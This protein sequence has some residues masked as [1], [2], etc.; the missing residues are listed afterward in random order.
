MK[1]TVQEQAILNNWPVVTADDIELMNDEF[2]HYIFFRRQKNGSVEYHTSCCGRTERIKPVRRTELP[3]GNAL[4]DASYHNQLHTCP[5]CSRKVT[6]KDLS[7]AGKRK[8]LAASCL[9][10]L[11]HGDK[12][13]LYADALSLRKDY[14]TLT[15]LTARPTYWL[16]SG[17][18]FSAGEVMEIDYQVGGEGCI[19]WERGQLGRKKLVQEPFKKGSLSSYTHDPY[20]V[21]GRDVLENHPLFRYCQYFD[22]WQYRPGGPR[23]HAHKFD[24]LIS[25]LTAYSMYPRQ[26]ELLVKAGLFQPVAELIW[27]RKKFAAAI[28]W[29]EPDIRKAMDLSKGELSQLLA[30][31]PDFGA[32]ECRAYATR[33]LG[34]SWDVEDAATFWQIWGLDLR[35]MVVLRFCRRYQ[36]PL[37]KLLRYLDRV[38]GEDSSGSARA[39]A[40]GVYSDY[41]DAAYHLGRCME[42]SAVLWP[43]LLCTAHDEA[44]DQWAQI[45]LREA[46]ADKKAGRPKEAK[47]RAR[48]YEFELGDLCIKFP[49]SAAAIRLEGQRL[50]HCVGGY[51]KRHLEGVLTILFLRKMDMP[52]TPY[53]TIEMQGN[54]LRQIHGLC[55][56]IGR[57]SPRIKHKGFLDTWM[58]W[59]R[60]GSPRNEDGSPQLPK[61]KCGGV[62]A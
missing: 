40:F 35:P 47:E 21:I 3:W 5:W 6:M 59:L 12:Q 33:H 52:N 4:L 62:V 25:Y 61:K 7:K 48:K 55:N 54:Q 60:E 29:E 53:V 46:E 8:S 50:N 2:P 22:S 14:E 26:I 36:L 57:V 10:V 32:L 20:A 42:H 11:L 44:T 23:G 45:Q 18:R 15:D 17:Y 24:D 34:T 16:C 37:G 30:I 49:M 41:L 1:R 38:T 31:R 27:T 51:A 9:V 56:D 13:A 43:E 28:D 19:A 58:R 39:A